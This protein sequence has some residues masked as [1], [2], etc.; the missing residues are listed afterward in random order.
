MSENRKGSD[1]ERG[2]AKAFGMGAEA[3]LNL[4][5]L[6]WLHDAAGI[7]LRWSS[8]LSSFLNFIHGFDALLPHH[9]MGT[10]AC[11]VTLI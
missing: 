8:A 5:G 1:F 10:L 3:A 11:F 7:D 9:P 6:R 2:V 4:L